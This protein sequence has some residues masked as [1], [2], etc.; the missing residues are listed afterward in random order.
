MGFIRSFFSD[1]VNLL[2]IPAVVIAL[3]VHELSHAYVAY[4][5]GDVTQQQRGRLTLNPL[6]HLDPIG[7]LALLFFGFGWAK[8]V[9]IDMR[10]FKN[11]KRGM[12]LSSLAGPVSNFLLAF[13]FMLSMAITVVVAG[14][15]T[16]QSFGGSIYYNREYFAAYVALFFFFCASINIGLG[17]FNLIPIP[18]LDGS[19]VALSFLP[20]RLYYTALRYESYGMIVLIALLYTGVLD[21]LLGALKGGIFDM[22]YWLADHIV[23]PIAGLF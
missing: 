12:A 5:L 14:D 1:P 15:D 4:R 23:S 6:K 21:G 10:Y 7:S 9:M 13:V 17:V 2:M 16:V 3:V 18:P 20:D 22:V 19:K 8:P 11:P